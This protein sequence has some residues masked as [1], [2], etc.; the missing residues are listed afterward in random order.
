MENF[1]L[2][3]MLY[4][5]YKHKNKINNKVYIGITIQKPQ[6]RWGKDG[7]GYKQNKYFYSAIQKY[8]WDNFEHIILF[9]N[10]EPDVAYKKEQ[11]LIA[12]YKSNSKEYGYNQS[13]GGEFG[14]LG[15]SMSEDARKK[16]SLANKGKT[17]SDEAKEKD[18]LAHL[19]CKNAM[20]GKPSPRKGKKFGAMSE[21]HKAKLREKSNPK[22]VMCIELNIVYESISQAEKETGINKGS[23][24]NACIGRTQ[25]AGKKNNQRLH[26]KYL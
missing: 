17:L 23:I 3:K 11:E 20:W 25:S 12:L 7:N 26:W 14:S 15:C 9:E 21:P 8:G 10:L 2:I 19:G 16:I 1:Y 6:H 13:V 24:A 18:R 5:V 4:T 22:K